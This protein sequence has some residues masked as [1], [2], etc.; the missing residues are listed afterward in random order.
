MTRIIAIRLAQAVPVI[1]IVAV[2]AFLLMHL[3]PGDPAVVIA[4]ADAGPQAIE[5]V[6]VELGLDRPLWEQ[7]AAVLAPDSQPDR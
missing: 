4:G 2:L 6:R 5:R 7:L 1:L 3:L